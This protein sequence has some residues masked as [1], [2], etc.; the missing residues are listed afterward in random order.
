[1]A[2]GI[3]DPALVVINSLKAAASIVGLLLTTEAVV[4]GVDNE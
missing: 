3:I 1:M 2:G 4:V